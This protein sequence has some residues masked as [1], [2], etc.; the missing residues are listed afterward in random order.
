MSVGTRAILKTWA[1]VAAREGESLV[2]G[3][4]V[5]VEGS[6]YRRPGARMVLTGEGARVGMI[7]GGC[8]DKDVARHAWAWTAEGPRVVLYDTRGDALRPQG[9]YGSGCDGIVQLLLERLPTPAGR[10]NPLEQLAEVWR[11]G[12]EAVMATFVEGVGPLGELVGRRVLWRGE[13]LER[14]QGVPEE[15][16]LA[17][18][19]PMR[20]APGWIR[21]RSVEVRWGDAR[22]TALVEALSPPPELL[23]FGAGDD[24]QPLA[25]MAA[26]AGWRVRV[27]DAWPAL[28]TPARFPQAEEV[29]CAPIEQLVAQLQPGRH[30]HAVVMTHSFNADVALIPALLATEAPYIGLM[31]P[32]R[33]TMNLMRALAEG[34]SLP[35]P[36]ALARVQTPVGLD[37]G[38]DAPEE[39]AISI[40]GG[41]VAFR[42]QRRGGL[43]R[44]H[45]GDA[46]HDPHQRASAAEVMG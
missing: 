38:A 11:S 18:S 21:P 8:L 10:I 15:V 46:I 43:L 6:A 42:N 30:T 13:A 9:A 34:G 22:L 3:T 41:V 25:A 14:D 31:G 27:A 12:Q 20:E 39:V 1:S 16:A 19:G 28:T 29:R 36:E 44:D 40:L 5:D 2:L 23:I 37:L 33:R 7:S 24:A 32:R 4:V 45:D 35:D 17:L 26:S